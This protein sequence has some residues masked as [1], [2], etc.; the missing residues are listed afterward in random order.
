[1]VDCYKARHTLPKIKI[2]F[3]DYCLFIAF[4][5]QLIAGPIVHHKEMLPQFARLFS[6]QAYITLEC[7]SKGVF[8]FSLGL[9][10][11]VF[12][13]DS[14]AKWANAGFKVVEN[15]GFLN[16]FESWATSLSYT[17]QLYFDFSGYCD[18][19]IGLALLFGIK[20]PIN[21][22]SPYKSLNIS[23]FWRRWHITLGRFFKNYLY[24]PLGG[25]KRGV[26]LTIGNLFI[27]AFLSGLWHGAGFGFIIWGIL[28][29]IALSLHKLYNLYC[30]LS[31]SQNLFYKIACWLVTFNFVNISWIFFRAQNLQAASNL[32]QG[33]FGLLWID[34]PQKLRIPK[35]LE[36]IEGRNDTL[37]FLVLGF[38][39]IFCFQNST[40]ALES[41]TPNT[42]NALLTGALLYTALLSLALTPYSEFIYFNF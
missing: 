34:L 11:K 12:I 10:K 16:F 13:A 39:L 33:M 30:P 17:F 36:N 1:M 14:F 42:K 9:F 20:L 7:I 3:L 37:I 27:V 2:N 18:M 23:D 35:I 8:I 31:N 6:A 15:G 21:F 28:H 41:F 24:I 25:N 38:V 29:G 19:A 40:K 5:P 32:L 22:N 26:A 4:F